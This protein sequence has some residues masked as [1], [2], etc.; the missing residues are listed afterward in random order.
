MPIYEYETVPA[1]AGE[2]PERFE[3]RQS[4]SEAPLT[5]HPE[6]SV[7]VRRVLSGGLTT[8][9]GATPAASPGAGCG[10]T[11]CCRVS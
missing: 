11:N 5:A 1:T 2:I 6:T 4:M 10:A 3:V 8:F 7:P 9:T